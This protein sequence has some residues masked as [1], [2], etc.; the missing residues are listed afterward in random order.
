MSEH[1]K[2]A[3]ATLDPKIAAMDKKL[4][5]Q[6][7]KVEAQMKQLDAKELAFQEKMKAKDMEIE[8]KKRARAA[9][10]RSTDKELEAIQNE[11]DQKMKAEDKAATDRAKAEEIREEDVNGKLKQMDD[12]IKSKEQSFD[13]TLAEMDDDTKKIE[14]H[15]RSYRLGGGDDDDDK[16]DAKDDDADDFLA[17]KDADASSL[18]QRKAS[19]SFNAAALKPSQRFID[20]QATV[21]TQ[22]SK[23]DQ[24]LKNLAAEVKE[25]GQ[26][27]SL[28]QV[29]AKTRVDPDDSSADDSSDD[30]AETKALMTQI[31]HRKLTPEEQA[32]HEK[33]AML[34]K[35][36]QE[37]LERM[38]EHAGEKIGTKHHL[39]EVS[40]LLERVAS[41]AE[42][43]TKNTVPQLLQLEE[44]LKK[45]H[46]ARMAAL[47]KKHQL[48]HERFRALHKKLAGAAA[49]SLMQKDGYSFGDDDDADV[50]DDISDDDLPGNINNEPDMDD[51]VESSLQD[52]SLGSNDYFHAADDDDDDDSDAS[53]GLGDLDSSD[54]AS[55]F[56]QT[57]DG[58]SE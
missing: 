36:V 6:K 8:N 18:L 17:G 25:F 56:L 45:K 55:S 43:P 23:T 21:A 34:K 48:T 35:K 26:A 29:G 37:D 32:L 51:S 30:D 49:S 5:A 10:R 31:E 19:A 53:S 16:D 50:S 27:S 40:S 11:M 24:E 44:S 28:A 7:E 14:K 12:A 38:S 2:N 47:K 58:D 4:E 15:T 39:G 42:K 46:A 54:D 41:G 33:S 57:N 13:K 1:Y 52:P 22:E 20:M 9:K 3:N